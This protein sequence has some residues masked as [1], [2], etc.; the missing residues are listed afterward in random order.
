VEGWIGIV[1]GIA[2]LVA[3]LAALA[4]GLRQR[5]RARFLTA[6]R[7]RMAGALDVERQAL[8]IAAAERDE[9]RAEIRSL[10]KII[11]ALPLPVWRRRA[12]DLALIGGNAAFVQAVDAPKE[13]ALAE[14]REL[15]SGVVAQE[16]RALAMRA[17]ATGVAQRESHHIVI[18]GTRRLLELTE[19]PLPETGE[20]L[21]YARDFT[22]VETIQALL[23]RHTDAHAEVLEK[24]AVAIAIYGADTRLSFFNSAFAAL[25]RLDPEWLETAPTIDEVMEHLRE[26]RRLPE[27]ADFR[28]FK[29]ELLGAFTSLITSREELL[30]LPD[31]RT[32]RLATAPHPLGGLIFVYEDVTDRLALE[33]S[34]NTLIE[35]QRET[36]DNLYEGIAVFGTDGRLKLWNPAFAKIWHLSPDD[37]GGEPHVAEIVEKTRSLFDHGGDWPP[38]KRQLVAQLMAYAASSRR[39]ERQDGSI[40]QAASV[41]LPDGNVLLLYLDVTDSTRVEAALRERNLAL[42]AADKLKSEFIASVS[43]ELRTPLN[44]I[45]GFAE[46][47]AKQYFGPLNERQLDYSEGIL[48]SSR[49]LTAL[50]NDI[51][52][53]ATIEAGYFALEDGEVDVAALLASLHV[54]GRDRAR[55]RGLSF[56]LEGGAGL[57]TLRGDERRLKQA[58]FNILSNA[59]KFTPEGGAVSLAARREGAELMV[60]VS[61]TGPGVPSEDQARIFE[62]FERGHPN[63]AGRQSGAGLGLPLVKSIIEQ[64]GGRIELTSAP[65]EGTVVTCYLPG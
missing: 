55:E 43:Y 36:L 51:L 57:G 2:V 25:W 28:S 12:G 34:F 5:A 44:V 64:H 18:G 20:L 52:D 10:E 46:L 62:K 27:Y 24:V 54:L 37:L 41:P 30:H 32:L 11:D 60:I 56:Q 26:R 33:R 49:Q 6:E 23:T 21:G 4:F 19:T 61:D 39:L 3:A 47:L 13:T 16:G 50:I 65:G 48:A 22:D 58:L 29:Q 63:G 17:R 40:L 59:F 53:L 8:A 9:A 15:G 35:V 38:L 45:G 7:D 31:E 42:E 14:Q 1:A